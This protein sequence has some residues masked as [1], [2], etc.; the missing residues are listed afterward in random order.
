MSHTS[1]MTLLCPAC[2]NAKAL[3]LSMHRRIPQIEAIH[4]G[5]SMANLL[6]MRSGVYANASAGLLYGACCIR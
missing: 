1:G 5:M 6:L 4:V 3:Q 2:L